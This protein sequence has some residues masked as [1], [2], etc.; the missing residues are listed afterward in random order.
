MQQDVL[1]VHLS[2]VTLKILSSTPAGER[3]DVRSQI[4]E[5]SDVKAREASPGP[6]VSESKQTEWEPKF[7]DYLSA[8]IGMNGISLSYVIRENDLPDHMATYLD[9]SDECIVYTPLSGVSFQADDEAVH[10]SLV[11][12]TTG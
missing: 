4:M 11:S 3:A 5:K 7:H 8:L 9:F 2:T 10:Q 6:L 1:T 12:F